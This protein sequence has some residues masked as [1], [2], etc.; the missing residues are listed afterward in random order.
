MKEGDRR[1]VF[2]IHDYLTKPESVSHCA[3]QAEWWGVPGRQRAPRW[4]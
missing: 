3:G 4:L 1:E 2:E